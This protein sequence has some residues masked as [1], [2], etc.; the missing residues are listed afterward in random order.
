METL[1]YRSFFAL[2]LTA[3]IAPACASDVPLDVEA[4]ESELVL[5]STDANARYPWVVQ[6]SGNLSCHGVL[7]EP[8]WVLTA[9]HCVDPVIGG[10]TVSYTR[11]DPASGRVTRGQQV[12]SISDVFRHPE[13]SLRNL[14]NDIALIRLPGPLDPPHDP[15]PL[16]RAAELSRSDVPNEQALVASTVRHY[17]GLGAGQVAVLRAPVIISG[18]TTLTAKTPDGSLCQGD[19]GSGYVANRGGR[20]VVIGIASAS[21]NGTACEK[22]GNLEFDATKVS[23]Y[24]P[25]IESFI[26]AQTQYRYVPRSSASGAPAAQG[27]PSGI[28]FPAQ[29][30]TNVV[31]RDGN[32]HLRELWQQ[33]GN[34]GTGDLSANAGAV[35]AAGDPTSYL[36][37][38]YEIAL[39]RGTNN[40]VYSLYWNTGAVG[41]D[42]L[43][44]AA[45]APRAAGN[46]V[47]YVTPDGWNHVIYRT[48][49]SSLEELW[50]Y[51]AGA[52]GAGN[53]TSVAKAPK[54]KGDPSPYANTATG[55]NIVPYRGTD[56]HIHVL[57]WYTGAVGHDDLSAAAGSPLAASN[58]FGYYRANDNSHQIAYRGTD[59]H[60]HELWWVGDGAV[61]WLDLTAASGA[62]LANAATEITG[63]YSAGTNTKHIFYRTNDG[64][65]HE[66]WWYPGYPSHY[67][68]DLT[69]ETPAPLA[70]DSKPTSFTVEGP[71]T[72]HLVYRGTD[73]AIHEIR[74]Q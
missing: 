5:G 44:E 35:N 22:K 10:V 67:H 28:W 56:N 21:S 29:S 64:H 54:A 19:S 13:W 57:Y 23:A 20:N 18:G 46:P 15:D 26:G 41:R 73:N 47:G 37:D 33:G 50:W 27:S 38:G 8:R 1:V 58:P 34:I 65:L 16:L 6:L 70:A 31:Y 43:S 69:V 68:V 52:P 51:G 66:I 61:Q 2:V 53:L 72:H 17:D 71:N 45:R 63:Y 42:G 59:N 24:V 7:I 14:A 74:W 49:D 9:A 4:L 48:E 39:Y 60:I 12:A 40:Q 62:P 32:G 30:V 11:T 3:L 55:E 25:W 36:A